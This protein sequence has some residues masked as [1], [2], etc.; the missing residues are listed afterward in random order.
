MKYLFISQGYKTDNQL[1]ERT[2]KYT[3]TWWLNS[4]LL[5]NQWVTKKIKEVKKYLETNENTT[6]QNLWNTA[7]VFLRAKLKVMQAY[8]RKQ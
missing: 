2:A 7:K 6:I 1:Q 5:N 4:V 8:L 3:K